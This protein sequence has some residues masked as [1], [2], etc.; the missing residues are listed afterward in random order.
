MVDSDPL[1]QVD[2]DRVLFDDATGE[3][4][5]TRYIGDTA[6]IRPDLLSEAP[7]IALA[8]GAVYF[9][10]CGHTPGSRTQ[11]AGFAANLLPSLDVYSRGNASPV[12]MPKIRWPIRL[13]SATIRIGGI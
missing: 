2:I 4:L 12:T 6:R 10:Q 3:L 13:P 8:A 9:L 11:M 5:M 7:A 1:A